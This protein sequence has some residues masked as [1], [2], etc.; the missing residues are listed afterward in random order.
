MSWSFLS[1]FARAGIANVAAALW[2]LPQ[3]HGARDR[4]GDKTHGNQFPCGMRPAN[5]RLL[6]SAPGPDS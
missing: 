4:G 1:S 5:S 2:Q 6:L 3:V